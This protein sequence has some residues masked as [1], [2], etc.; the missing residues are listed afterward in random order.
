MI[1]ES[2][3]K[4]LEAAIKTCLAAHKD[5]EEEEKLYNV[6]VFETSPQYVF[7]SMIGESVWIQCSLPIGDKTQVV[8]NGIGLAPARP[9]L[10]AITRQKKTE[11]V[12]VSFL[13][14]KVCVEG[15]ANATVT[16]YRQPETLDG[17]TQP[18]PTDQANIYMN[19]EEFL[20]MVL[21]TNSARFPKPKKDEENRFEILTHTLLELEED[22]VSMITANQHM[23]FKA[24]VPAR[25]AKP[26]KKD[27][28][29]YEVPKEDRFYVLDN[30]GC[31]V[32]GRILKKTCKEVIMHTE[33]DGT[34]F[35]FYNTSP[36][37][38]TS[39]VVNH[40]GEDY[41]NYEEVFKEHKSKDYDTYVVPVRNMK[42]ALAKVSKTSI[43]LPSSNV[44][45]FAQEPNGHPQGKRIRGDHLPQIGIAALVETV[46]R[47]E[48]HKIPRGMASV[49]AEVPVLSQNAKQDHAIGFDC[50]YLQKI[51]KNIPD[52]HTMIIGID[53]QDPNAG[54]SFQAQRPGSTFAHNKAN[55]SYFTCLGMPVKI[56]NDEV[57]LEAIYQS[58]DS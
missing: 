42:I 37:F 34:F 18:S 17:I 12:V 2:N 25:Y 4:V 49:K 47:S 35:W 19:T 15:G 53:S 6:L 58:L 13:D 32:L 54:V 14:D 22:A 41:I 40:T 8:E 11:P 38:W 52:H 51:F 31:S 5:G 56:E 46:S 44:M 9:F 57:D 50:T 1:F 21:Q 36:E 28:P 3:Y 43:R 33:V 23:L 39:L 7:V 55:P 26:R 29:F 48:R 45:L 20:P 10:S 30:E 24:T 16:A 27:I